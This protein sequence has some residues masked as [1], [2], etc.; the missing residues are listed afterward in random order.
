MI[1]TRQKLRDLGMDTM[2]RLYYERQDS[3]RKA[4]NAKRKK[5]AS[6]TKVS[7][8]RHEMKDDS[9]SLDRMI[10]EKLYYD[11]ECVC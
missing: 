7:V 5:S 4:Y 2:E 9:A 3:R 10:R 1:M 11:I 6:K 8:K